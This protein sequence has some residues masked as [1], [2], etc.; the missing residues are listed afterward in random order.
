MYY[1]LLI[2]VSVAGCAMIRIKP[3]EA[4]MLLYAVNYTYINVVYFIYYISKSKAWYDVQ[5]ETEML[6]ENNSRSFWL[7]K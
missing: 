5:W 1:G 2:R 6:D 3:F 7:Q 4:F